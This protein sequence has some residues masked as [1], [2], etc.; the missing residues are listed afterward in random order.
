MRSPEVITDPILIALH[1]YWRGRFNGDRLP[2]RRDLDPAALGAL[3]PW[4]FLVDVTHEP[5]TLRYRLIG[6]GVTEFLKR[7]FT[8]KIIDE[9]V[10]GLQAGLMRRIFLSAIEKR[11][12]TAVRGS[13]FYVPDYSFLSF[14][15]TMMPL[16]SDGATIDM[17]FCG[18]VPEAAAPSGDDPGEADPEAFMI[19]TKPI[20][21]D[22]AAPEA[23]A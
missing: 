20:F 14:C 3:L 22:E 18:Y 7:D 17:L 2:S 23:Q 19:I 1:R 8:G 5:L 11:D 13:L 10:Y 6:T 9:S 16:S 12:A 21:R 15:W 4:V